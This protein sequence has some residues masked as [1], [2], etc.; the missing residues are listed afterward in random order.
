MDPKWF[1]LLEYFMLNP[2][3]PVTRSQLLNHVWGMDVHVDDRTV[4]VQVGRLRKAMANADPARSYIHTVH[5]VGYRFE[6]K[7]EPPIFNRSR[8][9]AA[10]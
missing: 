10:E 9:K 4:D 7:E 2:G 8:K 3:R 5:S 1:R 6:V